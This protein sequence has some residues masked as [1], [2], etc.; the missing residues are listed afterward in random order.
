[1]D[2]RNSELRAN[3]LYLN[4]QFMYLDSSKTDVRRTWIKHGWIPP[5]HVQVIVTR[6]E[7]VLVEKEN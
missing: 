2:D 7:T 5:Q 1:M 4:K 6:E 3:P